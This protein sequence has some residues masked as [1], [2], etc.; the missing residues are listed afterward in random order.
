MGSGIQ[1]M[2]IWVRLRPYGFILALLLLWHFGAQHQE[3][4]LLPGPLAVVAGH[5]TTA[6]GV[7][8]AFRS[9]PGRR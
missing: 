9:A 2:S 3:V 7:R 8:L 1:A 5:A 4:K 6:S